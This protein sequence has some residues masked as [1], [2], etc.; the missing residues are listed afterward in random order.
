MDAPTPLAPN[1]YNH[2]KAII[3]NAINK[4]YKI[5]INE[6]NYNLIINIENEFIYFK[7]YKLDDLI[8]IYYKN[9]F[10]LKS[11]INILQLNLNLYDTFE[12]VIEL[13]DDCYKNKKIEINNEKNNKMNLIIK[14]PIGY[15]EHECNVILERGELEI[16]EK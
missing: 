2:S 12:K 15:K 9:K 4:E 5:N 14:Y 8:S 16:N 13:I 10:D 3:N 7:I 6:K 1:E 11:L